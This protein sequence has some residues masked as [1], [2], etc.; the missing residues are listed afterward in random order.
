MTMTAKLPPALEHASPSKRSTRLPGQRIDS[1]VDVYRDK[2]GKPLVN[3]L[4]Q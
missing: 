2:S 4:R 1:D 3:A